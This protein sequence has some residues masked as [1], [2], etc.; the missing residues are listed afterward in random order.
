MYLVIPE[1]AHKNKFSPVG[2][3]L[4]HTN[5]N[6][7]KAEAWLAGRDDWHNAAWEGGK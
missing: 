5:Q 6:D 3:M 2:Q 4:A 1:K 7:A